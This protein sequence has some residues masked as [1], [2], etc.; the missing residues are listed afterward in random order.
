MTTSMPLKYRIEAMPPLSFQNRALWVWSAVRVVLLAAPRLSVWTAASIHSWLAT[1][2]GGAGRNWLGRV[3]AK[4]WSVAHCG[5]SATA[6][7]GVGI[8]VKADGTLDLLHGKFGFKADI[9]A[10]LGVGAKFDVGMNVDVSGV[11]HTI[12]HA[13]SSVLHGVEHLIPHIHFP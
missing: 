12:E 9:G 13:A 1:A 5:F 10:A 11:P 2:G 6:Y 3:I 7:A 4:G 8:G